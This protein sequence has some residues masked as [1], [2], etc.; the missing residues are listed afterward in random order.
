MELLL[1]ICQ[2]LAR[3]CQVIWHIVTETFPKSYSLWMNYVLSITHINLF[4]IFGY[5]SLWPCW[6]LKPLFLQ[7]QNSDS[8]YAA[9]CLLLM[10]PSNYYH[11]YS[12]RFNTALITLYVL[13]E[14]HILIHFV[15][16]KYYV[17]RNIYIFSSLPTC[18]CF[19]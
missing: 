10:S 4:S 14:S 12:F 11:F 16:V 6:L 1:S 13:K 3:L 7:L 9:P 2:C 19:N 8:A 18:L 15:D 17:D 5:S